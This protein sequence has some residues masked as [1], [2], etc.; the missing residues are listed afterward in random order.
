MAIR[1]CAIAILSSDV[2][3]APKTVVCHGQVEDQAPAARRVLEVAAK[4]H[5]AALLACDLPLRR[6][7]CGLRV[8]PCGTAALALLPSNHAPCLHLSELYS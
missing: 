6:A 2:A 7:A 5:V 3:T 1:S 8:R 4:L